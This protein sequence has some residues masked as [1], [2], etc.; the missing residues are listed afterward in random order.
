MIRVVLEQVRLNP[1]IKVAGQLIGATQRN[2]FV[3][4]GRFI[5][6]QDG[7]ICLFDGPEGEVDVIWSF[8]EVTPQDL[9]AYDPDL[10]FRVRGYPA[11]TDVDAD[12]WVIEAYRV[13]IL[14]EE[15]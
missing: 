15:A 13:S 9:P 5:E 14:S 2:E 11:G 3:L 1:N 8:E 10:P 12:T 7:L 4:K 6:I